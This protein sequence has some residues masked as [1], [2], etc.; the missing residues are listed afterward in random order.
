MGA[1]NFTVRPLSMLFSV[2][3]LR[4]LQPADFGAVALGML[5]VNS[6]NIFTDLGMRSAVVR[7]QGDIEKIAFYAFTIA[8]A[9]SLFFYS[10]VLLFA[11]G[12][13]RILGGGEELVP[14]LRTL[15]LIIVIDGLWIVPEAL[16]KRK[17]QFKQLAITQLA[18]EILHSLVAIGLALAGFGLYSLVI[19]HIVAE[20]VR[21]ILTWSFNRQRYWLRPHAFE[22]EAMLGLIRFGSVDTSSGIARYFTEQVDTWFVG[23]QFGTTMV[24]YYA[25]AYD[26]TSRLTFL[27][28]NALFGQVLLPSYAKIQDDTSR[29]KRAYLKSTS[30]V[31]LTMAPLSLGLL[32]AAHTLVLVLFGEQWLP[33]VPVWQVF[34]I[35]T[36]VRPIS[37]N[38]GP[39]FQAM[40]LPGRN[41]RS[42]LVLLAV[43]VPG[44]LI[45]VPRYEIVGAAIAVLIGHFVAMLYNVWQVDRLL[46]GTAAGTLRSVLPS[47]LCGIIMAA[48]VHFAAQPVFAIAGGENWVALLLLIAIGAL[49][50]LASLLLFQR[51]LVREVVG[52]LVE[53]LG[54]HKRFPRLAR[55]GK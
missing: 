17:L 11:G 6:A 10:L 36:L 2:I 28:S 48:A 12:F 21:V 52:L 7:W 19:G 53:V 15:G 47:L 25:K 20:V 39:L 38:T 44:L 35:Y 27:F 22:R 23:R 14:V 26:I 8:M 4:L 3:L 13:A 16:L 34:S 1:V 45:L 54:L 46:P 55:V 30:M 24:G 37:G 50:Y 31:L 32:A 43:I 51:A 40:G 18:A 49:T 42:T 41:L 5:L 9:S 33:M 29:L